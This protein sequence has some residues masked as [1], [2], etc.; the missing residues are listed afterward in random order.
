[1]WK[2]KHQSSKNASQEGSCYQGKR[3]ESTCQVAVMG[4]QV[5]DVARGGIFQQGVHQK[6][7]VKKAK[8]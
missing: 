2:G 5:M 1:M 6:A 7:S 8:A 3:H 4:G